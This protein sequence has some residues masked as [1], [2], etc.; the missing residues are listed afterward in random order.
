[1]IDYY[2]KIPL[3]SWNFSQNSCVCLLINGGSVEKIII[4][5]SYSGE[6]RLAVLANDRLEEFYYQSKENI[7]I[8]DNIYF[9]KVVKIEQALQAV[10]VDYGGEKNGFLPLSEIC[11][12]YYNLSPANQKKLDDMRAQAAAKSSKGTN[13]ISGNSSTLDTKMEVNTDTDTTQRDED[14]DALPEYDEQNHDQ[15]SPNLNDDHHVSNERIKSFYRK[16]KMR[17]IIKEGQSILVQVRKEERGN[18]GVSLTTYI[19][20]I[21]RY[22]IFMPNSTGCDAVSRK[23]QDKAERGRLKA[24]MESIQEEKKVGILVTR[25]AAEHKT[26]TEIKRD[27]IYLQKLW[28][29][30]N[31]HIREKDAPAFI[32]KEGDLVKKYIRD[33]YSNDVSEII[34]SGQDA[35]DN[36]RQFMKMILPRHIKKIVKYDGAVPIFSHYKVEEEVS[37]LYENIVYLQSGGYLVIDETEALVAIDINSGKFTANKNIE[38][39]ALHTNLEAAKE[40]ARQLV[41]RDLSGLVVIDFIDMNNANNRASVENAFYNATKKDK[42]KLKIGKISNFGLLEMT[43]QRLSNSILETTFIKCPSC[44]GKGRNRAA[45]ATISSIFRA[46]RHDVVLIHDHRD[47]ISC[48][49]KGCAVE[50]SASSDIITKLL[51]EYKQEIIALSEELKIQIVFCID[52]NMGVDGFHIDNKRVDDSAN[53]PEPLSQID[54][55]PYLTETTLPSSKKVRL[56]RSKHSKDVAKTVVTK[57]SN[58]NSDSNNERTANTEEP[59]N[60]QRKVQVKRRYTNKNNIISTPYQKKKFLDEQRENNRSLLK[61]ILNRLTDDI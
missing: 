21:G 54:D 3:N 29:N 33:L 35:Y 40:I 43:R 7:V 38:D 18:K 55:L 57:Q 45:S 59:T 60:N 50:I 12:T 14:S 58:D 13:D 44:R 24:V 31:N 47:A 39:T 37:K 25:T 52:N 2:V 48:K 49:D 8:K 10:F 1:L 26:K 53:R 42:A 9:A 36:A 51:N 23:I 56:S 17:D 32:H 41:L 15:T 22:C 27:F 16:L 5:S 6:T 61:K 46:I 19:S 11:P 30:I 34:I 4:D 28:H 20:L